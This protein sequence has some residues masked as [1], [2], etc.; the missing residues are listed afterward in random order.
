MTQ[1][2][3]T[4]Y[5]AF[6]LSNASR[7]EL[8][9]AVP[10]SFSRVICHHVTL[11]F[12]FSE[13]TFNLLLAEVDTQPNVVVSGHYLG[14]DIECFSVRINDRHQSEVNVQNYHITHSLRSPAK[15][16]DSN[17]LLYYVEPTPLTIQVFGTIEMISK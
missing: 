8:I 2:D 5:L 4:K 14:D 3:N 11:A 6:V 16:V 9:Q 12:N 10:P 1:Y 13:R 17:R 15:P 7:E